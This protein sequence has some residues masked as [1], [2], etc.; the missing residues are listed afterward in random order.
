M[1][2]RINGLC[3]L[4]LGEAGGHVTKILRAENGQKVDDFEPIYIG[5]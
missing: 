1:W 4:S 3:K 5:K 2:V